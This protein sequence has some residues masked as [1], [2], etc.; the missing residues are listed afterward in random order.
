[1][2]SLAIT[3]SVQDVAQAIAPSSKVATAKG[4]DYDKLHNF[5]RNLAHFSEFALLGALL[6]VCYFSYTKDKAFCFLPFGLI[7]LTPIC[8]ECLQMFTAG[9]GAE[10]KDM[11]LDTAGG[12]LGALAGLIIVGLIWLIVKRSR[13]K[14][15]RKL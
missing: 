6:I 1:M 7:V 4:E 13:A 8:D 2:Q 14:R 10:L 12:C 3:D 5:I 15:E 9:R 11:L